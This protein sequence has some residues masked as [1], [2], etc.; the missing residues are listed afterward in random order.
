ME[1][2]LRRGRALAAYN[3]LLG[4]RAHFLGTQSEGSG[5]PSQLPESSNF[6][7]SLTENEEVLIASVGELL[8]GLLNFLC[9]LFLFH[10]TMHL[11]FLSGC[12]IIFKMHQTHVF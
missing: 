4:L 1:H 8:S 6:L 7:D 10:P 3:T 5:K 12:L 2:Y 11:V 9:F